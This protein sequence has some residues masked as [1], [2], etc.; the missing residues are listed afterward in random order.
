[1][2]IAD[3]ICNYRIQ[4]KQGNKEDFEYILVQTKYLTLP[5]ENVLQYIDSLLNYN[6]QHSFIDSNLIHQ[7]INDELFD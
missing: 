2:Q 7:I 4:T 5:K 6:P 1:M 3:S